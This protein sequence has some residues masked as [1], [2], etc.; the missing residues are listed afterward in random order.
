M[1]MLAAAV[2][3]RGR[4]F[5]LVEVAV[6]EPGPGDVRVAIRASGICHTDLAFRD[7]E[8]GT[9]LPMVL[10][11]E[12][13]GVV[14]AVGAGV[15]DV[16]VG[17]RVGLSYDS[18]GSCPNCGE[19][20]PQYCAEFGLRNIAG[21]TAAMAP[22]LA[23]PD[24]S[25]MFGNFFGQS[26][27]APFAIAHRRNLV[28]L[29]E[30][31]PFHLAAPLGCGMQTGAGAV[32]NTL[33]GPPGRRIAILGAGAV[34]LAA[35]M[36]ARVA[37]FATIIAVDRVPARLALARELGATHGFGG[38]GLAEALAAAA[39]AAGPAGGAALDGVID[40]TGVPALLDVGADALGPRGTLVVLG[41]SAPGTRAS[42]GLAGFLGGKRIVGVIE[43][44]ADP[45]R[46]VPEL[47]A[48]HLAGQFPHDRL[49]KTYPFAEINRACD[50]MESGATVKP[51]LLF[52]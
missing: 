28:K 12:G 36:A 17:D 30:A 46:F 16:Q 21:V 11:H 50:D 26:S 6:P 34:G 14:E 2:V 15:T 4:P 38:E 39:P 48:L 37:G 32:L 42:Y 47:A 29:P 31:L 7:L 49:V 20:A 10:G 13:A 1:R 51:V 41:L 40:T 52:D 22:P 44:D 27:F 9:P 25:P 43:G 24:G 5:E 33:A 19:G 8:M 18:C 45:R 23:R 3:T 35:V